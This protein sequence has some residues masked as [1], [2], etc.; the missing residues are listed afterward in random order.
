MSGGVL[1]F[2]LKGN[3][4][5]KGRPRFTAKK[6][7]VQTFTDSETRDYEKAVGV[8][9]REA[10]AGRPPF[11]GP[12]AVSIRFRM[13]IPVSA[14]KRVKAA[15]AA[16]EI[17]PTGRP[18]VDNMAKAIL[19]GMAIDEALAKRLRKAGKDVGPA[20]IVF[21]NDAQITRLFVVKAYHD[22][23]GVDIRVEAFAPQ[24]EEFDECDGDP[25]T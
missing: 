12:L 8:A 20:Q 19:D 6:G 7:F 16:G 9:A 5:G 24:T 10:M 17:A 2:S 15:M 1:I 11:S 14:T 22:R 25:N 21:K 13:P 3:P 4:R 18:D 23:P